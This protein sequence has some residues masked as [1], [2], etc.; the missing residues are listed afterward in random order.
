[1]VGTDAGRGRFA[2]SSS[3]QETTKEDVMSTTVSTRRTVRLG[4]VV[5]WVAQ[6][7]M[8]AMFVSA[9]L[10]KLSGSQLMVDMFANVGAGQWLRYVVGALEVAGAIGL[11][12]PRLCGLAATGL[13]ALMVGA[14]ITNV[15]VLGTSPA[16]PLSYLLVAG[17][18]AW[19]R[20]SSVR[21][22]G[23]VLH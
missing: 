11:L 5:L 16:I 22:L 1:V 14:T 18:I 4:T 8:A 19:F 21:Q 6:V 15:A 7:V 23:R 13:V 10:Q 17:A 12:V 2:G 20:R 9:G 3:Y